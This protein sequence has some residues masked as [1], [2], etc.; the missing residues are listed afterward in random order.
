MCIRSQRAYLQS[1]PALR[2]PRALLALGLVAWGLAGCGGGAADALPPPALPAPSNFRL[3][4]D[5]PEYGL[6]TAVFRW[7]ATPGATRYELYADPDAAGPLPEIRI[8]DTG[9]SAGQGS[10]HDYFL[11]TY[12]DSG[13]F[14]GY[15]FND[16]P[17]D[18]ADR[19][20][21]TYRL[22]ACDTSGCGPFTQPKGLDVI[23]DL[24]HEFPSGRVP[25]K[26]S[27]GLESRPRLSKDGLTLATADPRDS[28]ASVF[29]RSHPMQPWQRQAVL[30]S[31]KTAFGNN[32]ALSSD[33]NTLAVQANERTQ[34]GP[35]VSFGVVYVYQ[36]SGG[37]WSQQAHMRAT[38]GPTTGCPPPCQAS[39][40]NRLVLSANGSLLAMS[41]E[42]AN[43]DPASPPATAVF[44]FARSGANWVPQA[45]LDLAGK[46]ATS[47]ALSGD[48]STLA[49]GAGAWD[50]LPR[51]TSPYVVIFAQQDNGAWTRQAQLPSGTVSLFDASGFE[52]SAMELSSDG[53]TLAVHARN[54]PGH[55]QPALDIQPADLSCGTLATDAW[56]L[57]L[58]ARE[59]TAW[60][61]ETVVSRGLRTPW[62]LASDGNALHYGGELFT[63]SGSGWTCP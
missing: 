55:P 53:N 22:R 29:V 31:G 54:A 23:N 11:H 52:N 45:Y 9:K 47:L 6:W 61:R 33:G 12:T 56:Y 58:Y 7:S 49:V 18:Q 38:S 26:V 62:A 30:R 57:A 28:S 15:T 4:F 50:T 41:A 59:G 63:R 17:L 48:G 16:A 32:M 5:S 35:Y 40:A 13:E 1:L 8:G 44:T 24:S 10:T 34:S 20:N 27:V 21:A 43:S 46:Q 2:S 14:M 36:R 51:S 39:L 3:N 60:R 25:L 42:M 37:I 19:L